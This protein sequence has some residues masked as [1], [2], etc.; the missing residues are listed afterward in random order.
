MQLNGKERMTSKVVRINENE[1]NYLELLIKLPPA[2][3]TAGGGGELAERLFNKVKRQ[4]TPPWSYDRE[5]A[6]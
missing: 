2:P 4:S 5:T 6:S 1:Q 3:L